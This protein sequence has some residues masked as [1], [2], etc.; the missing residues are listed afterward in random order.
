VRRSPTAAGL[1]EP[2]V[3]PAGSIA[4]RGPNPRRW[5]PPPLRLRREEGTTGAYRPRGGGLQR[6]AGALGP[7]GAPVA[8]P[9]RHAAP[10]PSGSGANQR[11]ARAGHRAAPAPGGPEAPG[12]A[13][14]PGPLPHVHGQ[15]ELADGVHRA[16][17]PVRGARQARTSPSLAALRQATSS[18]LCTCSP[19]RSR[20]KWREQASRGAAA[21]PSP[22]STV[23]GSG[24]KT[25][26]TAPIP[27]PSAR[28]AIA[29]PSW[30]GSPQGQK[31]RN[32][33]CI[34][35]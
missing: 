15:A 10:A 8:S 34:G 6:G 23:G 33:H 25:R 18:S 14:G 11:G 22:L 20:R 27:R 19:T 24:S 21:S 2:R 5:W 30:S 29:H 7:G 9:S 35:G 32:L 13:P 4:S 12:G 28:A 16:P 26:A 17:H 31:T 3:A 1:F